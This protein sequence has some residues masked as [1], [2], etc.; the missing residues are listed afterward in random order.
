ML[1]AGSPCSLRPGG[2]HGT[3]KPATLGHGSRAALERYLH[4]PQVRPSELVSVDA[5]KVARLIRQYADRTTAI[6]DVGGGTSLVVDHLLDDGYQDVSVLDVSAQALRI[7]QDR[8]GERSRSVT[9][10]IADITKGPV[11]G[12]VGLWH[13]RAVLHF[14]TDRADQAS[15][16]RTAAGALPTG[17]CAVVAT[18][19]PDGP[20]QCSGLDVQRHDGASLALLFGAQFELVQEERELH[21]TPKGVEQRFCWAVLRKR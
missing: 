2:S 19:A 3:R 21:V 11:L 14:L 9:W 6:V 13:D 7:A 1:D 17:A 16:A 20:T 8:L 12:P 10:I 18:F 15:Y 4:E 5:A